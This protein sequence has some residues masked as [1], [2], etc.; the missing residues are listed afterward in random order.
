M[1]IPVNQS[2]LHVYIKFFKLLV[3][4]FLIGQNFF[5]LSSFY[6]PVFKVKNVSIAFLHMK[7]ESYGKPQLELKYYFLIYNSRTLP[8]RMQTTFSTTLSACSRP[9][10]WW[11]SCLPPKNSKYINPES[12]ISFHKKLTEI[13]I[14]FRSMMRLS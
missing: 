2:H 5:H 9:W 13:A 7:Q 3:P 4:F 1:A 11:A 10:R 8:Q 6:D 12:F 14:L